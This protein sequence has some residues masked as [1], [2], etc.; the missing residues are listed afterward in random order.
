MTSQTENYEMDTSSGE[1][2]CI[3]KNTIVRKL[4]KLGPGT[5][6]AALFF[7]RK[8]GLEALQTLLGVSTSTP[9]TKIQSLA[10][11]CKDP[12]FVSID[13]EGQGDGGIRE[14]GISS[15]THKS[16]KTRQSAIPA[17]QY[18][19]TIILHHEMSSPKNDRS[20]RKCAFSAMDK[21]SISKNDS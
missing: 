4:G 7:N 20:T 21:L 3:P 5:W 15:S 10:L 6:E 11:G 17:L 18:L 16:S 14:L 12:V 8:Y 19:H 1:S 2:W 13:I 9:S